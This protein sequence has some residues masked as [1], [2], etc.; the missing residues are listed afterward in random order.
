MQYDINQLILED[1]K[2]IRQELKNG[3]KVKVKDRKSYVE[4]LAR[5]IISHEQ[6]EEQTLYRFVTENLE[7]KNHVL[8]NNLRPKF[9]DHKQI[10]AL[11]FELEDESISSED[12]LSYL[13]NLSQNFNLHASDEENELLPVTQDLLTK[14]SSELLK[15][16]YI[17]IQN[18]ILNN[19]STATDRQIRDKIKQ[20]LAIYEAR[21][22]T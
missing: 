2:N 20:S 16:S 7:G 15:E 1:H 11:V 21:K 9:K 22:Q 8:L 4:K 10:D 19:I 12:W 6:A 5:L 18:E 13:D 3:Q 17:K 14:E